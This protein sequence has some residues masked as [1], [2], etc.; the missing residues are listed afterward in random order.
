MQVEQLEKEKKD[1]L[2][3]MKMITKKADHLERAFRKE[4]LSLLEKDYQNQL[5]LD[6]SYHEAVNKAKVEASK[7][8]HEMDL[9]VKSRLLQMVSDAKEYKSLVMK[10]REQVYAKEKSEADLKLQ[11]AKSVL[12]KEHLKT[13]EEQRLL[14]A[15]QEEDRLRIEKEE[16]L[17]AERKNNYEI[18][19]KF[20]KSQG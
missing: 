5:Q 9:E 1:L 19:N 3:K 12:I 15:K 2:N 14:K 4:E 18:F 7:K 8:Q 11:E 13:K 20:R 6:K 17:A 16:Q 10:Q